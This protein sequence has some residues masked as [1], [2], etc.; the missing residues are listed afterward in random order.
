MALMPTAQARV[1][2]V[3]LLDKPDDGR[4]YEIHGGE[5]VVV[6]S[7]LPRHQ[8]VVQKPPGCCKTT[9]TTSEDCP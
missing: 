1:G 4:R 8:M 3:D 5:L 9:R 7:P 6:P 2:Y